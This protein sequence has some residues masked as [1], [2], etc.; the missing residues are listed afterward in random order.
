MLI[1]IFLLKYKSTVLKFIGRDKK[2]WMELLI[3]DHSLLRMEFTMGKNIKK[4]VKQHLFEYFRAQLSEMNNRCNVLK[5]IEFE[6]VQAT[7]F[8]YWRMCAS[9]QCMEH[10]VRGE[11]W[12]ELLF[13]IENPQ[14]R[15][16][17][18]NGSIEWRHKKKREKK[19]NSEESARV[20]YRNVNN[21][22]QYHSKQRVSRMLPWHYTYM[23][24]VLFYYFSLF[25]F[26]VVGCSHMQTSQF[27]HTHRER[28]R[29]TVTDK[30]RERESNHILQ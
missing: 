6:P 17:H 21:R 16:I 30:D 4:Y 5:K 9:M 23:L 14:Q 19:E 15:V 3:V 10:L 25:A 27:S 20:R 12:N 24:C 2:H 18:T 26:D 7:K 1:Q 28:E 29:F 22:L 11:K 8:K 13:G